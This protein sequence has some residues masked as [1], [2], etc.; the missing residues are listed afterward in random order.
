MANNVQNVKFLRNGSLLNSR[1]AARKAL[2]TNKTL[3]L[4]GSAIL[5]RYSGGTVGGEDFFIKTLVGFVYSDGTN[6]TV[7][8]FDIDDA[9][10]DVQKKINELRTEINSKIGTDF[11]DS[12]NT[13]E[14]NLTAL[15]GSASDTSATTSVAGAKKYADRLIET[16]DVTDTAVEGSYVSQVSQADGKISVSRVALPDAS[17]VAEA[18]KVVTDVTQSKGAITATA[19]NITGIKLAG[20]AVGTDADI[21]AT[22]TLGQALGKL[23]AQINAMDKDASA[24]NGQ[25]VTTVAEVDGKVTETKANVKDL[26]LGGYAKTNDTGD[27]ASADTINVALSKLENKS[28]AITITNDDGSI[29]V[30]PSTS[31]TDINVKI[32]N[33]EHVLA[34][35]GNAGVYTNLKLNK[36]TQS[37]P[38]EIKERYQ[39]IA[40]DGSQIGSNIDIPKDSHIVSI[41]Y[42]TGSTDPH[43]Q[44]LEYKYID[45]SGN[46]QTTYVDMSSLIIEAEFASGVTVTNHVAHGV[47]DSTSEKNESD[48]AFLTVGADG[49][50][51]SGIKDAIDTKINKL[52]ADLSGNTTH[53]KVGVKEVDGK[54][55]AVTV[56]E[57]D[58]ASQSL[59][60]ALSGKSV[61]QVAMTGG[62]ANIVASDD[63]AD[64]TKKITI[65]TD[66]SQVK[67]TGYAKGSDSGA[68]IATDSI[69][70]AIGK[71]EN[72][73][74][75]KVD[76]LDATVSSETTSKH[77]KVVIVQENGVLT[78]VTLTDSDIASATALTAEIAARKAVDGQNGQTYAKNTSS[79]YISGA[80]SLN[81]ADVK[82][83]A[84]LKSLSDATVNEVQVNGVALAE[85]SNAVNVQI[86]AA[87]GTGAS[88]PAITVNTNTTGKVTISLEGL[89]CGT[90]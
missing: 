2:E 47:V 18:N 25:V 40:T 11:I 46:T 32:K 13:V 10:S 61:T 79:P 58:I 21:A 12:G 16:L 51:V 14:E 48:V 44:N 82:L 5:A 43:Y 8:I 36:I 22:D 17:S 7:T 59:L 57:T 74:D 4:D 73:I 3:G 86:S 62:T 65:N 90:Y 28:A 31:G 24:V 23:Q 67:L 75:G 76:A 77:V 68:V 88:N 49:F 27:I 41:T 33:N 1:E 52:D 81:D 45:A 55:T 29:N 80:T 69:N 89:D 34:K 85:T 87:A 39:L 60:D 72:R 35:D 9:G 64:G 19:S 42:I 71:L 83:A 54:L 84:E 15:S 20:Y 78:G 53:V 63:P 38:A 66:G 50:K 6:T 26:Q 70:A 37:L 30:T 56:A